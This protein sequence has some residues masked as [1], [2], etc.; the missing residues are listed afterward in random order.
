MPPCPRR[1]SASPSC[2]RRSISHFRSAPLS[3]ATI[4]AAKIR[5]ILH[6]QEARRSDVTGKGRGT[7]S[8][9][10]PRMVYV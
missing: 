10:G 6:D 7:P 4:T 5:L 1:S 2:S 9:L 8:G 3:M